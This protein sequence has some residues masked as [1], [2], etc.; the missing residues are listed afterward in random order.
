MTGTSKQNHITISRIINHGGGGTKRRTWG[1]D[2]CPN[3]SRKLP[4]KTI[5]T[6][7]KHIASALTGVENDRRT[8]LGY[9]T[10]GRRNIG[11]RPGRELP[12]IPPEVA[13]TLGARDTRDICSAEEDQV[14][15]ADCSVVGHGAEDP[16][17]RIG[18]SRDAGPRAAGELPCVA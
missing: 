7:K 1:Y 2:A 12:R 5:S 4:G 16:S 18:T 14:I 15:V 9:G 17:S 6:E 8:K 3:A 13:V 11:P 10:S